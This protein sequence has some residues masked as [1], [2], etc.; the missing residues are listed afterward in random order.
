F[1]P[2]EQLRPYTFAFK[3]NNLTTPP[4]VG[5]RH[6]QCLV[7]DI[8]ERLPKNVEAH[9]ASNPAT[10]LPASVTNLAHKE[11]LE[12]DRLTTWDAMDYLILCFADLLRKRGACF[13]DL[14]SVQKQ[15]DRLKRAFPAVVK[16]AQAQV[17]TEQLTRI[18]RGLVAEEV[19][20]HN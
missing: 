20:I 17:S 5:L 10:G 1:V 13:I 16:A 6:N 4:Y 8:A 7:N 9:P 12:A 18:L 2:D 14:E 3:V 11:S 19:S 15:V